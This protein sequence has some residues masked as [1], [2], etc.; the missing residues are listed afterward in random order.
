MEPSEIEAQVPSALMQLLA[1]APVH[2]A[3]RPNRL[4][5]GFVH[6]IEHRVLRAIEDMTS[7]LTEPCFITA[8]QCDEQIRRLAGRNL[9]V[10]FERVTSP[11]EM[12]S[13]VQSY[14]FQI[15]ADEA[16]LALCR[17]HIWARLQREE[18]PTDLLFTLSDGNS[19]S[20]EFA[21][22]YQLT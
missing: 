9:E 1:I 13:I 2:Y 22:D 10:S 16:R 15:G 6:R 12:A 14:A 21:G 5:I 4:L 8:S 20:P 19:P 7:C 11:A 18:R 17:N 3:P